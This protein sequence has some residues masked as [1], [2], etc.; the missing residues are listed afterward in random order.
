MRTLILF[1]MAVGP[2]LAQDSIALAKLKKAVGR[3]TVM[4]RLGTGEEFSGRLHQ[5]DINGR[6]LTFGSR[7]QPRTISCDDISTLAFEPRERRKK[8]NRVYT[9]FA[10]YT[11]PVAIVLLVSGSTA[12]IATAPLLWPGSIA[13]GWPLS[14]GVVERKAIAF[15]IDCR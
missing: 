11:I 10:S 12:G 14:H 4:I 7:R 3:E 2:A 9:A 13:W 8:R 5:V 6:I 15:P 1:L